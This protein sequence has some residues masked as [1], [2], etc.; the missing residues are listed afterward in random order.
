MTLDR[1]ENTV[2]AC[3]AAAA[4]IPITVSSV[5]AARLLAA[6]TVEIFGVA[7]CELI[8]AD[9]SVIGRAGDRPRHRDR[10]EVQPGPGADMDSPIGLPAGASRGGPAK[11][12]TDAA[13]GWTVPEARLGLSADPRRMEV[14]APA[15]AAWTAGD[16]AGLEVM[17]LLAGPM[18]DKVEAFGQEVGRADRLARLNRLQREFLRSI[19]HNMRAPLATIE[20]AASDLEELGDDPF[21]RTRAVAI[22]IEEQRLARLVNQV[23]ILSRMETGT[24]SLEG[25][26]IALAPLVRRVAKELGI[27]ERVE[28]HDGAPGI[29]GFTDPAAAE[30]I[31]WILLDNAARYAPAGPIRAG[32]TAAGSASEPAIVLAIEDEGPGVPAPE[33]RRIFQRFARGTAPGGADGT[34]LGLSVA[35]G[36]ARALG[37]DVTYRP[38]AIGARFEV[39]MP[40]GGGFAE[41]DEPGDGATTAGAAR[42]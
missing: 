33:R 27:E 15:G 6:A 7:W 22:R 40:A 31:A 23:L 30:Q 4:A 37:G 26:P 1:R 41:L 18:L 39:R 34:G 25:E 32:I 8:A 10:G 38:G 28:I 5:E 16:Q 24:L 11:N 3:L 13:D 9:G 21:V 14:G 17:A 19:S 35:R 36:L 29:V 20:L 2:R 12:A 42:A